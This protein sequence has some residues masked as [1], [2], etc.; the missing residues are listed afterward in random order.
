MDF[1]V[2]KSLGFDP[3]HSQPP[4]ASSE[5]NV[6]G[7]PAEATPGSETAAGSGGEDA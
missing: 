1:D 5:G 6:A 7:R 4:T 3:Q 2:A